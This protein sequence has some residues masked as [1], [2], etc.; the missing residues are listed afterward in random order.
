MTLPD[1]VELLKTIAKDYGSSIVAA[2]GFIVTVVS[3]G[4]LFRKLIKHRIDDLEQKNEA[5]NKKIFDLE[6][7]HGE[8]ETLLRDAERDHRSISAKLARIKTAFAGSD[9]QNIWLG[10]PINQPE[11]YHER[12]QASIPILLVANLKGGVGKSTIA[13]NLEP[14]AKLMGDFE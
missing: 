11:A 12:M 1:V 13:A 9:D 2:L 6:R 5:A 4:A 3:G 8:L 10:G 7:S 14:F